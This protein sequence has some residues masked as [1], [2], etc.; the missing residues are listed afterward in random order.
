MKQGSKETWSEVVRRWSVWWGVLCG[1][2]VIASLFAS[3]G[4]QGSL[5]RGESCTGFQHFAYGS[6]WFVP[7]LFIAGIAGM[8]VLRRLQDHSE[9]RPCHRCGARVPNGVLEC[10]ACGF[11]FGSVGSR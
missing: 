3:R 9:S 7:T 8:I 1:L 11:D 5:E 10:E 2:G 6:N 4:C